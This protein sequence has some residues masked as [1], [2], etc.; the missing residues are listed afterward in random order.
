MKA[1]VEK[2]DK[3]IHRFLESVPGVLTWTLLLSP[4]WLGIIYP[5]AVVYMLTLFTVYWSF[6]SFRHSIGLYVGYRRYK[7]E[8]NTDWMAKCKK[9]DFSQL[10]DKPT[11]PSSLR[12]IKHLILIP[13]VNEPE[14]VIKDTLE[15]LTKQTFPIDQFVIAIT[16]EERGQKEVLERIN[17][18]RPQVEPLVH[19]FFTYVHPAGIPGEAIG[20]GAAN[21]SWGAKHAVEDLTNAGENL[22]DYVFTTIDADHVLD[23]QYMARL[24]HS[25]LSADCRDHHYYSTA[26]YLFNNNLWRVPPMMRI[27]ANAVTLGCLSDWV[28]T[29]HSVKDTFSSYSLSLQTLIDADYWD[30]SLGVDDTIIYW[31]AFFVRNGEFDGIPHYIPFSADAV[32]G[33]NFVHSHIALYKQLLRWGWGA[34]D[35]PLSVKEFMKNSKISFSKKVSWLFKHL[36]KRVVLVNTVFMITFGF[37]LVT[38]VNPYVKQSNFAY[39]LPKIMSLIL[40]LTLVCILPGTIF[41]LKF[42]AP[43]P[44]NWPLW[45]R[46]FVIFIEGPLIIINLLTYSFF[47][48]IE[49]QTRMLLGKKMKDLYHTPKV[50]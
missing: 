23:P 35:F 32:E 10:P 18:I 6:L 39:S 16:I 50:G 33:K 48:W 19:K 7:K 2:H 1:L 41:R 8:M 26:V 38:L 24:T 9:L 5:A 22:R 12:H 28:V 29:N 14:R 25:Y 37:S 21:R 17:N 40:T 36:E 46:F 42:S 11:L 13:M 4:I 45:K 43:M 44:A 20:A 34:I 15:A 27:E 30:V 49:A 47:P 3:K 31:R